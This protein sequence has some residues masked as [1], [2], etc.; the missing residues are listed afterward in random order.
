MTTD[1]SHDE[2]PAPRNGKK[3]AGGDETGTVRSLPK[4]LVPGLIGLVTITAGLLTWRAGQLGS[5]A[6]FED[7]QSVG[8]TISTQTQATEAGLATLYQASGYV[9]FAA[10]MAEAA[11]YDDLAEEAAAQGNAEVAGEL[12]SRAEEVRRS[13]SVLAG[14][15]GVL[16]AQTLFELQLDQGA[17]LEPFD[18]TTR[19]ESN[20]ATIASRVTEPG[21][22]EP[23]EWADRAHATRGRVW[24]LRLGATLML[25]AVAA[26]TV[27]E[28]AP[29]RSA[30]TTG[31][32]VGGAVYL[33]TL[34]A[35]VPGA[36]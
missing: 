33:I 16:D 9:S 36:W 22:L 6:A 3:S 20:R 19:F 2:D 18:A 1:D 8:Q 26:Y 14:A 10:D 17:G 24:D 7:R 34:V 35:V 27:A 29:R 11:A 28:L 32:F 30:R 5:S 13:A 15:T 12:H 4:W 25:I 23:Q 21:D 31:F